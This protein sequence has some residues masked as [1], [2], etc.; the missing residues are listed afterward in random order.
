M[1]N[2]VIYISDQNIVFQNLGMSGWLP[3]WKIFGNQGCQRRGRRLKGNLEN[4]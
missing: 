3:N 4:K 2:G 1:G